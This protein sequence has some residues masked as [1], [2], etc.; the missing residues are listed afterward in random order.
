MR[1]AGPW[2]RHKHV[3]KFPVRSPCKLLLHKNGLFQILRNKTSIFKLQTFFFF[4]QWHRFL[5]GVYPTWL[6]PISLSCCKSHTRSADTYRLFKKC[7]KTGCFDLCLNVLSIKWLG[8]RISSDRVTRVNDSTQVTI[9]GDS[10]RVTLRNDIMKTRVT[11]FTEWLN[12]SHKKWLET[13]VRVI[14]INSPNIWLKNSVCL[15]I[16]TWAFCFI[17]LLLLAQT[18]PALSRCNRCVCIGPRASGAPRHVIKS[19]C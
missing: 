13:R 14:F 6:V 15:H 16:K 2:S 10:T 3:A 11:F 8:L 4:C 9:F 18:G 5:Y 17:D 12:S 1:I 7:T 19:H